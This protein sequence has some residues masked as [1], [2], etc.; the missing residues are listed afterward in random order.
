MLNAPSK[1]VIALNNGEL[2]VYPTEAVWGIGCDPQNEQA[3]DKLLAAKNRPMEKGVIIIASDYSQ[4][5]HYID[6]QKIPE[7]RREEIF[8]AW[9]GPV[10][11]LMPVKKDVCHWITG[12]SELIAVRVTNHPTVIRICDEFGGAIV[13]TS[14]NLS[15]EPTPENLVGVKQVFGDK[16][17]VYVDEALGENRRP[18][19][20]INALNGQVI[21]A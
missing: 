2:I 4:V 3:F 18:S 1:E 10:T 20:I 7:S 9:P 8:A 11:W 14:A 15:G 17:S 16:V 5:L 12:G 6:E 13:S 19:R 21:R